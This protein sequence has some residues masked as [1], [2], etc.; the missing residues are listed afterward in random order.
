MS[1]SRRQPG[2]TRARQLLRAAGKAPRTLRAAGAAGLIATAGAAAVL[3]APAAA[4]AATS[5]QAPNPTCAVPAGVTY[6]LIRIIRNG[7]IAQQLTGTS[8]WEASS[9]G[10]YYNGLVEGPVIPPDQAEAAGYQT[11]CSISTEPLYRAL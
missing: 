3:S 8:E 4:S 7:P 11:T 5:V 2:A 1:D 6:H 10:L 9:G